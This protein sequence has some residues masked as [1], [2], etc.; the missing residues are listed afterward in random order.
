LE[1]LLG[2]TTA[3]VSLN[4]VEAVTPLKFRQRSGIPLWGATS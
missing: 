3:S 4:E 2:D 1:D